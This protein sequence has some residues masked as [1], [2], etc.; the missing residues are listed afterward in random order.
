MGHCTKERADRIEHI[1][2]FM[3]WDSISERQH[4]LVMS[5]EDQFRRNGR[6]SERQMEILEDIFRQAAEA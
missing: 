4:A 2:K 1:L 6:L 3:E 5:F